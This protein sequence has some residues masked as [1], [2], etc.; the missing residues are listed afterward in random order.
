MERDSRENL[1]TP[2]P[3][4]GTAGAVD[5]RE[6]AVASLSSS[7]AASDAERVVGFREEARRYA[8]VEHDPLY[9]LL[10]RQ[11][12]RSEAPAEELI[13]IRRRRFDRVL[14]I[15]N[16]PDP[17]QLVAEAHFGILSEAYT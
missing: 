17:E 3:D 9:I 2:I 15:M 10:E 7:W 13:E 5:G 4:K 8:L 14:E 1:Q 6:R 12:S 16:A 11:I